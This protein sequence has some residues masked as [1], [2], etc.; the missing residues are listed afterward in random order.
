MVTR[1]P[2]NLIE[3]LREAR[4]EYDNVLIM[5]DE[6]DPVFFENKI[7][8]VFQD[9]QNVI[10]FVDSRVYASTFKDAKL[11]GTHYLLEPVFLKNIFHPKIILLLSEKLGKLIL[12][13]ANLTERGFTSN[14]EIVSIFEFDV[15]DEDLDVHQVFVDLRDFLKAFVDGG[16]VRSKMHLEKVIRALGQAPWLS[17]RVVDSVSRRVRLLHNLKEPIL[18]QSFDLVKE[19]IQ[20]VVIM[21]PFFDSEAKVLEFVANNICKIIKLVVQP[22]RVMNFPLKK[23]PRLARSSKTSLTI[24][25][26]VFKDKERYVHAKIFIFKTRKGSY[27]LTGS[28]NATIAGLL[29]NP[30]SGNL[31]TCILR[32]ET[33]PDYFGYLL[34]NNDLTI[35][36]VQLS[37]IKAQHPEP[38]PL[39]PR[40]LTLT[41]ARIDK[42]EK[43]ILEFVP[44]VEARYTYAWICIQQSSDE[45]P[46]IAEATLKH[47]NKIVLQLDETLAKYFKNSCH[48][49]IKIGVDRDDANPLVSDKRWVSTERRELLASYKRAVEVISETDGRV[50]LI[51][52]L[53]Q[54]NDVAEAPEV[55][56]YYL[57]FLD[58]NWLRDT[59]DYVRE[60][61]S[62]SFEPVEDKEVVAEERPH[63]TAEEALTKILNRNQRRLEKNASRFNKSMD[64][65]ARLEKLFN[66]FIFISKLSI[67]F[68]VNQ[69][70]SLSN[71]R[72][73]KKNLELLNDYISRLREVFG[74]DPINKLIDDLEIVPHAM[75]LIKIVNDLQNEDYKWRTLNKYVIREFNRSFRETLLGVSQAQTAESLLQLS[76]GT[77]EKPLR[78]YKEFRNISLQEGD[79]QKTIFSSVFSKRPDARAKS[80]RNR[81]PQ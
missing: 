1:T 74:P 56:M 67:W 53:N 62:G 28:A 31:E 34:K 5:T 49:S 33:R 30:L 57:S 66:L 78:E 20:E 75:I 52:L 15:E 27:C 54:L 59:V 12:G 45:Q 51:G 81:L 68:V 17:D 39:P 63:L 14:A 40:D 38:R 64:A 13:S 32:Y 71:L 77:L 3:E 80:K 70:A 69:K 6:F 8:P 37:Q 50:G 24:F 76:K 41:E 61:V 60:Q 7:L 10:V 47:R 25:Q 73:I 29:S 16:F 42:T 58:F 72:V 23:I 55:I 9:A 2:I 26:P 21:S 18:S 36:K 22:E 46:K 19:G 11:A 43:L 48:V 65:A 79:V 4:E 35:K 44:E